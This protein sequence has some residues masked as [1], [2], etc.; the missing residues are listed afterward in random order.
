MIHVGARAA[1]KG[2]GLPDFIKN[3]SEH[4]VDRPAMREWLKLTGRAKPIPVKQSA[5]Q[6]VRELRDAR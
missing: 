4:A 3:K 6:V 5:A 1:R 2:M